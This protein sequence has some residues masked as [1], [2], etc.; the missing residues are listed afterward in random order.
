VFKEGT[1][2]SVETYLRKKVWRRGPIKHCMEDPEVHS[3]IR[4]R[5]LIGS[6]VFP[7]LVGHSCCNLVL[8]NA[9]CINRNWFFRIIL[10]KILSL[11][12]MLP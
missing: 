12:Q 6:S 1:P 7:S 8:E 3:Q 10:Y 4:S 11:V 5:H 9:N 2:V